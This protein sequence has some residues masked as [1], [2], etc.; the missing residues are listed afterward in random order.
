MAKTGYVYILTSR[1]RKV[2]YIGVTSNLQNRL[3]Q[4]MNEPKGFVKRYAAQNLVYYETINGMMNAIRREKELKGWRRE[5]KER[6]I[7]QKNP[8][9]KFL[10]EEVLERQI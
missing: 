2:L 6:L 10:N 3:L 7:E 4:H 1:N 8:V 9:W 5:K